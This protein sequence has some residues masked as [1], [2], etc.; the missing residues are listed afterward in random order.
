MQASN[1]NFYGSTFSGGTSSLAGSIFEMTPSG[2]LT[3]LYS[4]CPVGTCS[5]DLN[6][7]GNLL[8]GSDG[9]VYGVTGFSGTRSCDEDDCGTIFK[10]SLSG[11]FTTIY[12][13]CL[14]S[15]ANCPDGSD[16]N[17]GL[18]EGSDGNFYGTTSQGGTN[19]AGTV[20][21]ITPS[22]ILTTLYTFCSQGGSTCNDGEFP[23]GSLVLGSDGNLYGSTTGAEDPLT[24]VGSTCGTIFSITSSGSFHTLFTF[25]YPDGYAPLAGLIQGDDGNFYGTTYY[26]GAHT[27]GGVVFKLGISPALAAP[28]QLSLSSSIIRLTQQVTLSWNVLNAFSLTMQQCYAF[29]QNSATGAGAWTGLQAGALNDGVYSGST[30]LTPTAEGTYTYALTCGGVESNFA[31]LTVIAPPLNITTSSLPNGTVDVAYSATLAAM[32]GVQLYAWSVTSGSLPDGL[33]L[34][35]GTGVISGTPTQSGTASFEVQVQDS[36]DPPATA[37]ANLSITINPPPAPSITANPSTVTIAAPGGSG[38]STLTVAN[39]SSD[40]F[41]FS[42][43]GLPSESTCNF[44][45]F[46]GTGSSGTVS[47]QIATTAPSSADVNL[48]GSHGGPGLMYAVAL[49]GLLAIAGV[50]V[51]RRRNPRWT[52]FF[53]LM[54]MLGIGMGLDG[55][56]GGGGSPVNPGT[57]VGTTSV[58]VTATAGSQSATTTVTVT[59]Q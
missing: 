9:N 6:P 2:T 46:S 1:G 30:E 58:T 12:A 55:C 18:V 32:G 40:S 44:G 17:G 10:I 22:G 38:T 3:T 11:E 34:A 31:T 23:Y 25:A 59:V 19:G 5:E 15:T 50:F 24:C 37:T 27:N 16:P 7:H 48:P 53:V 36:E 52:T 20:F 42:C 45:S 21:K 43:S 47:L 56:G 13:F 4:Y 49:P 8:Q 51:I 29:V 39:F 57:P 33:A 26:G 41:Q 54:V 28:V 14:Q 35:G